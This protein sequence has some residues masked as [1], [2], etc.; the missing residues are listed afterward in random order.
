MAEER[1]SL[2]DAVEGWRRYA[3]ENHPARRLVRVKAYF[4]DGSKIDLPVP[5]DGRER[6]YSISDDGH[7]M[8]W[9]GKHYTFTDSQAPAALL[10]FGAHQS[11][12]PEVGASAILEAAGS[13]AAKASDVFKDSQAWKD[14]VIGPGERRNTVRLRLPE[15][16]P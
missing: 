12:M 2:E 9:D 7:S 11:G 6:L 8:L 3:R 1:I 14:G 5:A 13:S 15:E 16:M 10:L 4:D